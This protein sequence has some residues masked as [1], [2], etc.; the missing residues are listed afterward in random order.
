MATPTLTPAEL[1]ERILNGSEIAL[2]DVREAQP[3][4]AGHILTASN[5]PLSRLEIVVSRLVPR[6]A[7]PVVLC[8]SDETLAGRAAEVLVGLGYRDVRVLQGGTSAWSAA[9]YVLFEGSNV[10]SK[11]F[12]EIVEIACHT[13]AMDA[14]EVKERVD[15][16]ENLI[17]L[18][19]RP[20]DEYQDFNIPGGIDCPNSELA[21]HVRD[22]APDPRTTIII[23]CAGRTR[24]IIGAQTLRNA[25]VPNP[26][27]ALRNGTIG[28]EWAGLPLEHGADRRHG[29]VSAEALQ[30]SRKQCD[31]LAQ[32][33][34][35]TLIGMDVLQTWQA[36]AQEH[37]LYLFDV[38]EPEEFATGSMAKAVSAQGTQL[39]Q[40]TDEYLA[41]RAGRI[42]LVDDTGVRSR[43]TA[44]WL[45]QLGFPNVAVLDVDVRDHVAS[46]RP[47]ADVPGIIP[48]E[49]F[50]AG[51]SIVDLS[52]SLQFMEAHPQGAIWGLRSSLSDI[53]G[54][55]DKGTPVAVLDDE[56]GRL[57][58]LA[59]AELTQLGYAAQVLEG[60]LKA[61]CAAGLPVASGRE[62]MASPILDTLD[63]PFDLTGDPDVAKRAY[64]DWELQLPEQIEKDGLLTFNPLQAS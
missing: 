34:G 55:L 33:A 24:S 25:G 3:F 45:K 39:V 30:W 57:A 9:G 48:S 4:V 27:Y 40:A 35:V 59:A 8:D 18:D 54:H 36:E 47:A 10:P 19:G 63:M 52:F 20:W 49:A 1:R 43:M 32:R 42:V 7:T 12:G 53:T 38:R 46:S 51:H 22:L 5:A 60:G 17:I 64:I 21:Y 14:G 2:L 26:V 41:V 29:A 28:W 44:S 50:E 31:Q 58:A 6:K 15:A 11:A 13:P 23:N 56:H 61:W 62:G 16:G 37:T